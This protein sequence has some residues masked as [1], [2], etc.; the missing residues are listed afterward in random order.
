MFKTNSLVPGK[1]SWFQL[2]LTALLGSLL[3]MVP[4]ISVMGQTTYN[5]LRYWT[6]NGTNASTDSMGIGNLNF[7]TYNSAFT[8]ENNGQVGKYLTLTDPSALIDG[9]P[10]PLNN[11]LTIEFLLKPGYLFNSSKIVQRGDDAFS[12]RM[13]YS[14]I[15]FT[16]THKNGSGSNVVNEFAVDLNGQPLLR[17]LFKIPVT[18][19]YILTIL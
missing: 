3:M 19:M 11:A 6:F 14:R 12:V 7:T 17:E 5:P 4:I 15:I 16:T 8:I 13:E 1:R 10:L 2:P 18:T 9:G